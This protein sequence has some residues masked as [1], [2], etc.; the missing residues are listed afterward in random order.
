[1]NDFRRKYEGQMQQAA[2][3]YNERFDIMDAKTLKTNMEMNIF[4]DALQ[5][6]I[7]GG[8]DERGLKL[9][10]LQKYNVGL[11]SE[12]FTDDDGIY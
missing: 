1:M 4:E 7:G 10:T 5:Y 3:P 9:T 8:E 12:K 6:L 2:A 11:G